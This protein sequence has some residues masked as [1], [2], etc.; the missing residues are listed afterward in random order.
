[1]HEENP[2]N[3]SDLDFDDRRALAFLKGIETTEQ[4][5]GR[6]AN[7]SSSSSSSDSEVNRH[8]QRYAIASI[9]KKE[10]FFGGSVSPEGRSASNHS[11]K[12]SWWPPS[13]INRKQKFAS[14][15]MTE[16][17][18]VRHRRNRVGTSYGH[19]LGHPN[20]KPGNPW[21]E[22][23]VCD[24]DPSKLYGYKDGSLGQWMVWA[25]T[26]GFTK[27]KINEAFKEAA[28]WLHKTITLT[29]LKNL[30]KDLFSLL[31]KVEFLDVATVACAWVHF[32]RLLAPRSLDE[33]PAV[34]KSTRKLFA[35]V[36]LLL[37]VKY[38]Q[39][40]SKDELHMLLAWIE[41]LDRSDNL[42][43]RDLVHLERHVFPWL[44]FD[45]NVPCSLIW[46]H[47]KHYL[48]LSCNYVLDEEELENYPIEFKLAK[49]DT[50]AETI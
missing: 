40:L 41:K 35:T 37:S 26:P 6:V 24:P 10:R 21:N 7:T 9:F 14:P 34:V 11:T 29:K 43:T 12:F 23:L 8:D 44:N 19:K 39:I 20:F 30:K 31:D 15:L 5:L 18:K 49:T 38:Y 25:D 36:C 46:P 17:K 50:D 28:P 32:E 2:D 1:M 3:N 4:N 22:L 16:Q 47:V 13:W 48:S 45:L 27:S 33:P 42:K